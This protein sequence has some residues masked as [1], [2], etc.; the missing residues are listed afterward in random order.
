[1]GKATYQF[2]SH[3]M[4]LLDSDVSQLGGNRFYVALSK[5]DDWIGGVVPTVDNSLFSQRQFRNKMQ[6][7]KRVSAASFV[8]PRV[9]WTLSTAY[10]AYDDSNESQINFYVL[11]SL[12]EVFICVEAPIDTAGSITLSTIEPT[13]ALSVAAHPNNPAKSFKTSDGYI[14][15]YMYKMSA[16]ARATFL[17]AEWMPVKEVGSSPSIL[18]EVEQ[19]ALQDSAVSGEIINLQVVSGGSGYSSAPTVNVSTSTPATSASFTSA[20]YNNAVYKINLDTDGSGFIAHGSS[21]DNSIATLDT[22]NAII[23]T[24]QGPHDGLNKNPVES[25]K[26]KSLAVRAVIDGDEESEGVPQ[27]RIGNDYKQYGLLLNPLQ[28]SS[29]NPFTS[30]AGNALKSLVVN[31]TSNLVLDDIITQ[32]AGSVSGVAVD[33]DATN[34]WYFQSDSGGYQ[35]FEAGTISYQTAPDRTV[36]STNDPSIDINSGK[37]LYIGHSDVVT[38]VTRN[39]TQ[40][41]E[42]RI[43]INLEDCE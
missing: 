16:Y 23:K 18:E 22:G 38:G 40:S 12:F 21:A 42:I 35:P 25:L 28:Y 13:K 1:M 32:S 19:L 41:D 27:I 11:N 14:W 15:R 31:D 33:K 2:N 34:I 9:N 39:N 43:I 29:S 36:I 6:A 17:S 30:N 7:V 8:I 3:V 24:V 20:I 37:L 26:A 5:S 10:N 4:S